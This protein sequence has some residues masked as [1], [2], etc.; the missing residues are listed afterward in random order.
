MISN[1]GWIRTGSASVQAAAEKT[2]RSNEAINRAASRDVSMWK[3]L[4]AGVVPVTGCQQSLQENLDYLLHRFYK[5]ELDAAFDMIG[6]ILK[7]FLVLKRRYDR[8]DAV[9]PGGDGF[10]L[11]PAD[12][13]NDA[14]K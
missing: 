3:D 10:F 11:E 1:S 12:W 6:D 2:N 14:R 7:V 5:M 9:P 8:L 13:Q 4:G